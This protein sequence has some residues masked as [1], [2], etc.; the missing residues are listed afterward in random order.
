MSEMCDGTIAKQMA[1]HMAFAEIGLASL[2]TRIESANT[3][4]WGIKFAADTES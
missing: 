4:D 2:T 3:R 1:I